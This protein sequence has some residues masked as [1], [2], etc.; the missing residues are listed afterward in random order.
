[1]PDLKFKAYDARKLSESEIEQLCYR[2]AK[3]SRQIFI[4]YY[5]V[6]ESKRDEQAY[7]HFFTRITD[8]RHFYN[9]VEIFEDDGQDVGYTYCYAR[10]ICIDSG[11]EFIVGRGEVGIQPNY[12]GNNTFMSS[13]IRHGLAYYA[14]N[15][16]RGHERYYFGE[17]LNPISYHIV[18][19]HARVIYPRPESEASEEVVQLYR[20]L[21]EECKVNPV[22]SWT[23]AHE[24]SK[25]QSSKADVEAMQKS[26]SPHIKF[27]LEKNLNYSQGFGMPV[28][29]RS[30]AFDLIYAC[31]IHLQSYYS[32]RISNFFSTKSV[33]TQEK[34]TSSSLTL[35][36]R[37]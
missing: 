10:K 17:I 16:W 34:E 36:P 22:S 3:L 19:K 14:E 4:R 23:S 8:K 33:D 28:L 6:P 1:M 26:T 31:S 29:V 15:S 12:R 25:V 20:K 24:I 7:L 35:K 5:K 13:A 21:I 9:R 27:F 30:G 11:K 18:C 37:L 2:L 32:K